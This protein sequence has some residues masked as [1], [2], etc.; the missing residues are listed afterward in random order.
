MTT[1]IRHFFS[2]D[3]CHRC[4]KVMRTLTAK[5]A[6]GYDDWA[7]QMGEEPVIRSAS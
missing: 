3:D 4:M 7:R 2:I 1:V 6:G 5:Y